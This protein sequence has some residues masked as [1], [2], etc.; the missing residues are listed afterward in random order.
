MP[1]LAPFLK[2][3]NLLAQNGQL[4]VPP[5]HLSPRWGKWVTPFEFWE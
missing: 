1:Y 5:S 3:G 4:F 2:Y